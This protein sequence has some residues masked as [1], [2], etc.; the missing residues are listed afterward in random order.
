MAHAVAVV[1]TKNLKLV[2]CR[3]SDQTG[4]IQADIWEDHICLVEAGKVYSL[5]DFHVREWSGAI[6]VSTST[7]STI[8][9]TANEGVQ[10]VL[11][12]VRKEDIPSES[13]VK[14]ACSRDCRCEER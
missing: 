13:Q 12:L 2:E 1:G 4:S 11:L 8:V 6:K 10:N 7:H 9:E 5:Q 14:I 3:F